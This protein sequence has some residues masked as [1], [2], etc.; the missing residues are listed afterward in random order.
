MSEPSLRLALGDGF[1]REARKRA[2]VHRAEGDAVV[3]DR[4][5]G[6]AEREHL[7]A[8]GVGEDRAVPRHEAV[9]A[10]ELRDQ[11]LAGPEVQVV[12]VGEQDRSRRARAPR[13][14]GAS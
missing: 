8:A 1:R 3:V 14:D 2:V 4:G 5:D 9:Q 7:E 10:A 13:R 12:R 11:V 6:V